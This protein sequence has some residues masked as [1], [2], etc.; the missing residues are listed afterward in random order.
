MVASAVI[1]FSLGTVHLIITFVG[2]KLTPRDPALQTRMREVS[3]VITEETNMWN[4]W[5]G[6][7][8]S[9]S[10]AAMLFGLIYGFLAIVH[11]NLLFSSPYLLTVGFL[12]LAGLFVVGKIYWFSAPF[13]GISISL[14]CYTAGVIA[15][16]I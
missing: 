16:L 6:F 1:L 5:I 15:A 13:V 14:A 8:I 2:P 12:T 9:H 10:M 4:F 7:N 3:P 11:G